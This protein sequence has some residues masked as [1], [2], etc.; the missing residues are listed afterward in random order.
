[1]HTYRLAYPSLPVVYVQRRIIGYGHIPPLPHK[2]SNK[3]SEDLDRIAR[4]M[5]SPRA[6]WNGMPPR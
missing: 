1:M 4:N 6:Q 2:Q 3:V 5:P